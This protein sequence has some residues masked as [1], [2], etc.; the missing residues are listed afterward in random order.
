MSISIAVNQIAQKT[1]AAYAAHSLSLP[2]DPKRAIAIRECSRSNPG[3]KPLSFL[4]MI[5]HSS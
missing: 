3:K 5:F 2:A 1:I 4:F